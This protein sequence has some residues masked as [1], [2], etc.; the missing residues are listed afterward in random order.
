ME[1]RPYLIFKGECQEAIELY[2]R[3]FNT[4]VSNIMRFSDIPQNPNNNMEIPENKKDWIVMATMPFGNN[5]LSLSDTVG[6]LNDAHTSRI[7]IIVDCSID[8]VKQGFNVLAEEGNVGIPLQKTFFSPCHGLV[9]DKFG[10]M[11]NFVGQE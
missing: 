8:E 3:A 6:E 5:L 7:G 1:I 10:V 2:K 4:D 9:Y 11:W